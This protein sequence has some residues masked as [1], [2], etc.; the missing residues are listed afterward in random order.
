MTSEPPETET[1]K[2]DP[3][4]RQTS[5]EETENEQ[6]GSYT[7][8]KYTPENCE[9]RNIMTHMHEKEGRKEKKEEKETRKEKK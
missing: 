7:S 4:D 2:A 3:P 9:R 8:A 6:P 1:D 5:V